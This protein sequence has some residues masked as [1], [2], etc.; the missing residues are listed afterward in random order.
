MKTLIKIY[1][2]IH[3]LITLKNYSVKKTLIVIEENN[4]KNTDKLVN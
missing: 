4:L 2:S 3:N 1:S